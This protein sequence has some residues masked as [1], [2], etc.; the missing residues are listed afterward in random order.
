MTLLKKKISH[1]PFSRKMVMASGTP[2]NILV[3]SHKTPKKMCQ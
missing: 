3:P 2:L 1:I